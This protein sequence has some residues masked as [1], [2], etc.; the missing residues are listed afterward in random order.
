MTKT[1]KKV[2]ESKITTAVG[3]LTSVGAII[4]T[5]IPE[6]VRVPCMTAVSTTENPLIVGILLILGIALTLVGPSLA[7]SRP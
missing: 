5:L 2:S 3:G 7:K 6:E 1:M 4:V